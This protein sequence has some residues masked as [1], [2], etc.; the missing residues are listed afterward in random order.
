MVAAN[1]Y[2]PPT[3]YSV[4]GELAAFFQGLAFPVRLDLRRR[5]GDAKP[6]A[7]EAPALRDPD[8]SF[9]PPAPYAAALKR[10]AAALL[11]AANKD[12]AKA[13]AACLGAAAAHPSPQLRRLAYRRA[14]DVRTARAVAVAPAAIQSLASR[15][16]RAEN[17]VWLGVL[18]ER[19]IRPSREGRRLATSFERGRTLRE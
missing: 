19:A 15:A 17:A 4:D 13:A 2:A 7:V 3:R 10:C 9:E 11:Y 12:V 8:A 14:M 16:A 6:S 18:R 5:S 1:G